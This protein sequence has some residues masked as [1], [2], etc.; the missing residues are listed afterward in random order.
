MHDVSLS[1]R[2]LQFPTVIHDIP[3]KLF[4]IAHL[5]FQSFIETDD[6]CSSSALIEAVTVVE[7]L[8]VWHITPLGLKGRNAPL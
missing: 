8:E 4:I 1:G 5:T 6:H 2:A 3:V 7:Q